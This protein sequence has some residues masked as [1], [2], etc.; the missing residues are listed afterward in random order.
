ML[1]RLI[2]NLLLFSFVFI[3]W[4]MPVNSAFALTAESTF[5]ADDWQPIKVSDPSEDWVP[6]WA[7]SVVW[8]QI[9]PERFRNGD[10]SNDPTL[11]NIRNAYPY[12]DREPWQIHPWT[13]DWYERQPYEQ[14]NGEDI[15][16]NI[17]RR[18]FG[19]DLQGIIDQ[20]DYL[21]SLGVDALYLNPVFMAPSSHKYDTTT[22]RHVD[23]T[24]GP[25]PEGDRAIM[26]EESLDD[27]DTWVWTSA[28]KLALELIRQ[29]HQR[30]MR[31]IFDGVFNHVGVTNEA[32]QDVQRKQ[33]NSK[34]KDWFDIISW[35]DPDRGTSFEYR[36]C[37]ETDM[38]EFRE[39]DRGLVDGP[40][41]YIF[42]ITRRWLD[43]DGDPM[44]RDGIDGWRLDAARKVKHEFWQD[45]RQF[46]KSIN[47]DA[48]LIGETVGA[49]SSKRYLNGDEFDGVMNYVV[50]ITTLE[51]FIN[52]LTSLQQF[53]DQLRSWRKKF[54]IPLDNVVPNFFDTHDTA[55]LASLIVNRDINFQPRD[56]YFWRSKATNPD[57]K[58][59]QPTMLERRIQK[60]LTIFQMTYVEVPVVYY[61]NEVGMWGANDPDSR[62]P[63]IWED[64]SYAPEVYLPDGSKRDVPDEV[65]VDQDLFNHYQTLIQ[66]RQQ[67]PA[68]QLGNFHTLLVDEEREIYGFNRIYEDEAV[69][70]VINGSS[71]LE[72]VTLNV[73]T[74]KDF[75]D[76][77]NG[78]RAISSTAD[79][80]LDLE[81][82]GLW[83]SILISQKKQ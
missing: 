42:A 47:P 14:A 59:R 50:A 80:K 29:V 83:G 64:L 7:K 20:L 16:F 58:T 10:L 4:V 48:Y 77:L 19:G 81:I 74:N 3:N 61:G 70:V 66:I 78:D 8:Y 68:L 54:D 15:W 35:E 34:Y 30:G 63:M 41:Q 24:F 65:S 56:T 62:K 45:W 12:D 67:S 76:V 57:Y 36:A 27:P 28:D 60:M 26:A 22:Y 25:D 39:G 32:F 2:F 44:T 6:Q 33:Q 69:I 9:F 13:A 40:R 49:E 38:P 1:S 52:H 23:P 43:P 53:D 75:I 5:W 51:H 21:Q 46:V 11:E 79:G 71:D 73:E 55:R 31:I 37:C 72:K 82:E 17:F 18:R